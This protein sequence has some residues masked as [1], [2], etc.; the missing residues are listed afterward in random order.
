MKKEKTL[1]TELVKS[2]MVMGGLIVMMGGLVIFGSLKSSNS[3]QNIQ[4]VHMGNLIEEEKYAKTLLLMSAAYQVLATGQA[5]EPMKILDELKA[6]ENELKVHADA[7]RAAAAQMG[8]KGEKLVGALDRTEAGLGKLKQGG[9]KMVLAFLE[10]N[11]A[12]GSMLQAQVSDT[13]KELLG[14]LEVLSNEITSLSGGETAGTRSFLRTLSIFAVLITLLCIGAAVAL[15]FR[16]FKFTSAT[17]SK[18]AEDLSRNAETLSTGVADLSRQLSNS[19]ESMLR[20]SQRLS[21]TSEELSRTTIKQSAAIE[22]SGAAIEEITAMAK[23]TAQHCKN[24]TDVASST[25]D[26]V[27]TGNSVITKMD[28]GMKEI[29]AANQQMN[30]IIKIIGSISNKTKVINDIVIKTQLLSFNASIEAARAGEYGRGFA[31]VAEEVGNLAK[32][33]GQAAEEIR[34]LIEDSNAKVSTIVGLIGERVRRG[35]DTAKKCV[36]VF[37]E[38]KSQMTSLSGMIGEIATATAEQQQ[39]LEQTSSAMTEL[40]RSNLKTREASDESTKIGKDIEKD[41]Q[42]LVDVVARLRQL[43]QKNTQELLDVSHAYSDGGQKGAKVIPIKQAEQR[44]IDVEEEFDVSKIAEMYKKSSGS[45]DG[46]QVDQ[47]RF[48]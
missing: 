7:I 44:P 35:E 13:L 26:K 46:T 25:Q 8:P 14:E 10:N 31:V 47:E 48:G 17:I 4:Q 33:S 20:T 21:G 22:E 38:V 9:S 28:E 15:G 41:A 12:T 40:D 42:A 24:C 11:E 43:V 1:K 23:K 45:E 5:R 19:N 3:I 36:E 6:R 29:A 39:G 2:F 16:L 18:T 37:E 34:S 32:L 30:E 27:A